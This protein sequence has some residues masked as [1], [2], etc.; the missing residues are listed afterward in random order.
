MVIS[1][2]IPSIPPAAFG[3]LGRA[4]PLGVVPPRDVRCAPPTRFASLPRRRLVVVHDCAAIRH[5]A[6]GRLVLRVDPP[7]ISWLRFVGLY[8]ARQCCRPRAPGRGTQI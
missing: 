5:D 6:P 7:P 4:D 2:G 3:N 1:R 8:A